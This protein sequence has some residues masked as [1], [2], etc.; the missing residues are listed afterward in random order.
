MQ[1]FSSCR[2]SAR[3]AWHDPPRPQ[4]KTPLG[5][6]WLPRRALDCFD[7]ISPNLPKL[8]HMFSQTLDKPRAGEDMLWGVG[9]REQ[10]SNTGN[11]AIWDSGTGPVCCSQNPGRS[12][13]S[14]HSS[15]SCQRCR[16]TFLT[17]SWA[18]GKS[19][20]TERRLSTLEY[21][22]TPLSTGT[23]CLPVPA[24]SPQ[25]SLPSKARNPG[26]SQTW[27]FSHIKG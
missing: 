24:I 18:G 6:T 23:T 26:S 20:C 5:L 11:Q 10:V 21:P 13:S 12:D 25:I 1:T 2:A 9:G 17:P 19:T 4:A 22:V 16:P 7:R 15:T 3:Q 27:F 14:G 8:C